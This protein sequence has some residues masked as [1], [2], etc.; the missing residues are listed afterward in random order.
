[1]GGIEIK[2]SGDGATAAARSPI[3][4]Y[5]GP[6][7]SQHANFIDGNGHVHELYIHP[8]AGWVDND[9]TKFGG[10]DIPLCWTVRDSVTDCG[11]HTV[12]ASGAGL[13]KEVDLWYTH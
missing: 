1:M 3:D 10:A 4:G 8:G 13:G 12:I 9:L 5:S 11:Q 2:V 6:D 7:G